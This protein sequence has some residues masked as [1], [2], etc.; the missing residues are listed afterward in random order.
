M[1][2]LMCLAAGRGRWHWQAAAG[3]SPLTTRPDQSSIIS[4]RPAIPDGAKAFVDQ[5]NKIEQDRQ[6]KPLFGN[7]FQKKSSQPPGYE[8][9]AAAPRPEAV[10]RQELL[11]HLQPEEVGQAQAADQH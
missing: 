6:K 5:Q 9:Q 7:W 2:R 11:G 1:N 3:G 8:F 10:L 4:V